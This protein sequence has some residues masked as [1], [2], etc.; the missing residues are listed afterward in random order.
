MRIRLYLCYGMIR[1]NVQ[2]PF[3]FCAYCLGFLAALKGAYPYIR[4]ADGTL[5]NVFEPFII[6]CSER[7]LVSWVLFG[8]FILMCKAPFIN[9]RSEQ[10]LIR[11]SRRCW[12]DATVLSIFVQSVG[13]YLFILI[14]TIIMAVPNGFM[15]NEWSNLLYSLSEFGS[16]VE[17]QMGLYIPNVSLLQTWTVYQALIHSFCLSLLYSMF[18]ALIL[19]TINLAVHRLVGSVIA[20]GV[21]FIGY[22]LISDAML[23]YTEFSLLAHGILNMHRQVGSIGPELFTSYVLFLVLIVILLVVE[24]VVISFCDLKHSI[25]ERA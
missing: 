16:G 21:H 18:L 8:Y 10:M 3:V 5:I 14:V 22:V 13:Y 4:Y 6:L 9:A 23:G 11:T 7:N 19:F 15:A 2:S 24:H 12:S 20:I 1:E 25:D 17:K